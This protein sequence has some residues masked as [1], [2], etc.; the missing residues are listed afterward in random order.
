MDNLKRI[1]FIAQVHLK[2][3]LEFT[4]CMTKPP[5]RHVG[6]GRNIDVQTQRIVFSNEQVWIAQVHWKF[7]WVESTPRH[8]TI[9]N[10]IP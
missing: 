3:P 4:G 9:Q 8:L 5:S 10:G 6:L 1:A 2:L 7:V